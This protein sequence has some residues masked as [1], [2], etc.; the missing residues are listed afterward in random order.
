MDATE[1]DAEIYIVYTGSYSLYSV[2]TFS[3]AILNAF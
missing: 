2:I 1:Q 3:K